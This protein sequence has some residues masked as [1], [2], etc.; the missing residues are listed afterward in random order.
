[1][2]EAIEIV[3]NGILCG[4]M[5]ALAAIGWIAVCARLHRSWRIWWSQRHKIIMSAFA[6]VT[7]YV[8]GTKVARVSAVGDPYITVNGSYVTNNFVHVE[9][10]KKYEWVPDTT[11]IMIYSRELSQTNTE[12]WVRVTRIEEGAWR[13]IDFPQDIAFP[14]AT[15]Y[16]FLVAAN[17]IPEPTIH[18][19]GVWTARGFVISS[20]GVSSITGAIPN[21][22]IKKED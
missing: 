20:N 16:N 19:N 21:S 5:F 11:M 4:G 22:R 13:I 17:Y 2:R 15:N 10:Q 7:I 14:N 18:T 9:I 3:R 6:L 8:G 12:D 1:M